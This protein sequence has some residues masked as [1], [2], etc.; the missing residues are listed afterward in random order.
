MMISDDM[1]CDD[2]AG[3][4]WLKWTAWAKGGSV[5]VHPTTLPPKNFLG[6][7]YFICYMLFY[8]YTD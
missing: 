3:I 8:G 5:G 6:V 4:G 2:Y 7:F 1:Y